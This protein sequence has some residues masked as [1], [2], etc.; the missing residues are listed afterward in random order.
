M[1]RKQIILVFQTR[2][3]CSIHSCCSKLNKMKAILLLFSI[4]VL[5]SCL[6][7]KSE[8]LGDST[9]Y[10]HTG[11]HKL[12]QQSKEMIVRSPYTNKLWVVDRIITKCRLVSDDSTHCSYADTFYLKKYILNSL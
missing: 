10:I 6:I 2:D 8:K 11:N 5:Y 4:V 1:E 3:E 7:T 12:V 9:P